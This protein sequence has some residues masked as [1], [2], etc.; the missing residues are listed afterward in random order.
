MWYASFE[1]I[2][3]KYVS[4]VTSFR[5][6]I[7]VSIFKWI[8]VMFLFSFLRFRINAKLPSGFSFKKFVDIISPSSWSHFTM[9]FFLSGFW[10]L[11]STISYWAWEQL[12]VLNSKGISPS[13]SIGSPDTVAKISRSEVRDLHIGKQ[14]FVLPAWKSSI[15][16]FKNAWLQLRNFRAVLCL[17]LL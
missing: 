7:I 3:V 1:S 14:D 10:I 6:D 11:L 4:G 2:F 15:C 12:W 8:L 16:C 13:N 17:L 9:T 5:I